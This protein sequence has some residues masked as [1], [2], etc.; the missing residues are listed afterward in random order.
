VALI[1]I[2]Y[3]VVVR[4]LDAYQGHT[5]QGG[6]G[7][8][9]YHVLQG[10]FIELHRVAGHQVYI[11]VTQGEVALGIHLAEI[12]QLYLVAVLPGLDVDGAAGLVKAVLAVV[13]HV[14]Y[15]KGGSQ[16]FKDPQQLVDFI[17]AHREAVVIVVAPA[18]VLV[19]GQALIVVLPAEGGDGGGVQA[20][21]GL[22]AGLYLFLFILHAG[23]DEGGYAGQDQHA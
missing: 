1:V 6:H 3:L 19:E 21:Y 18:P 10:D 16:V 23:E 14:L 11:A 17:L 4:P 9:F 5:V 2:A 8:V 12:P 15:G 20:E 13:L 22:A 7:V